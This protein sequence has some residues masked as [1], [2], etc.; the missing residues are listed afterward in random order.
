LSIY[1]DV[2]PAVHGRWTSDSLCWEIRMADA[3]VLTG[4]RKSFE[5]REVLCGLDLTIPEGTVYGL[6]GPNGCGKTTLFRIL[7]GLLRP[8]KGTARVLGLAPGSQ[9][10]RQATG[11][12]TQ[13]EALYSDLTVEENVRFFGRLYGLAG[14]GLAEAAEKAIRLADLWDRRGSRIDELSGGMRRRASL[15]CAIVQHPRL[16][17]LDEPTV[18]VDPELRG[19]FW[20]SFAAWA[21]QGT[22]LL[23]STHHLEEAFHC[24]VL[25]LMREG[26][27]IAQGPPRELLRQA[28]TETLEEAF[29]SFA[30]RRQ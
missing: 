28:G 3:V 27:I 12:M 11:Y 20:D 17:I 8:T 16:L 5:K 26:M 19:T 9:T 1:T 15:A 6:V 13:A 21:R 4:L 22:T 18:G 29:L 30:R 10:A 14:N 7:A 25:G 2:A 24:D 23:V